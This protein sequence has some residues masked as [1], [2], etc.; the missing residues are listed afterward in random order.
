[1]GGVVCDSQGNLYG[2]TSG[3]GSAGCVSPLGCG[4]VFEIEAD[5]NEKVLYTFENFLEGR[6]PQ[7]G[8][9]RDAAGNLYGTTTDGGFNHCGTVFKVDSDGAE[10]LV[11][12]FEA[13][14]DG[15][16][17]VGALTLGTQGTLYGTTE[18]GGLRGC[19][20]GT[21]GTV[22]RIDPSGH[23]TILYSFTGG[24]DGA[25]PES[26]LVVD[27][28][29]N[30]YGTTPYGGDLSCNAPNCCGVV[31]KVEPSGAETVLHTF[32]GGNAD[33]WDPIA[34]VV[35]DSAGNLYGTTYRGGTYGY[36]TVYKL[37]AGGQESLLH[38]FGNGPDGGFPYAGLVSDSAGNLYGTD[39]SGGYNSL[40]SGADQVGGPPLPPKFL[41]CEG[42]CGVVYKIAP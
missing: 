24:A 19:Q 34:G 30:L 28:E 38:I 5:G 26:T 36:G 32:K 13:P 14:G 39:L 18:I 8:L 11:H 29:G 23:E 15:C 35:R 16:V 37:D 25:G 6:D 41:P 17:P 4:L 2:T 40:R 21:C 1:M 7:A 9:V 10:S 12:S 27:A 31:F 33:G 42:G 22:F 20:L 3:G